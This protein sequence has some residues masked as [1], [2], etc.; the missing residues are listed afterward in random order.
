MYD[1]ATPEGFTA[2]HSLEIISP[3]PSFDA[4]HRVFRA[5]PGWE[6]NICI[7]CDGGVYPYLYELTSG[8]P[9]GMTIDAFTGEITWPNPTSNATPTVRVTDVLGS[10]TTRSWTIVVSASGFRHMDAVSGSD[11]NDGILVADGGSGPWQTMNKLFTSGGATNIAYFDSGTYTFAGISVTETD[12]EHGEQ[13]INWANTKTRAWLRKPGSSTQPVIDW[14][15]TGNGCG[16]SPPTY[17]C[18]DRKP[19][20]QIYGANIYMDALKFYRSMVMNFHV[21]CDS[22]HFG[23][24]FRRNLFDT[25]GPGIDGG[26]SAFIM[27]KQSLGS[28]PKFVIIQDNRFTNITAGPSG[29]SHCSVKGYTVERF[30]FERNICDDFPDNVEGVALK[31]A[32]MRHTV[33]GNTFTSV[34]SGIMGNMD[35]GGGTEFTTGEMCFNLV[36]MRGLAPPNTVTQ[37]NQNGTARETWYYRNTFMGGYILAIDVGS[38]D[39]PFHW[40]SNVI[41]NEESG[42]WVPAGSGVNELGVVDQSRITHTNNLTGSAGTHVDASGLL[43]G[44]SRTAHLYRRGHEVPV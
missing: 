34:T 43:T 16:T 44:A 36:N 11:S 32:M 20:L 9:A 4:N 40:N 25:S 24:T 37:F 19:R 13:F 28:A 27:F 39:G 26:N 3:H 10:T 23:T 41:E 35:F 22:S 2:P 15:Y 29:S 12:P 30:L 18:G 14:E 33:R 17:N 1:W 31:D 5:Y 7:A 21:F 8:V 42:D 6:Y 38:T